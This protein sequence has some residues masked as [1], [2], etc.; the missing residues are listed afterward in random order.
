MTS[1]N[2]RIRA[3]ETELAGLRK[4]AMDE[5][6]YMDNGPFA[7]ALRDAGIP[8]T[9]VRKRELSELSMEEYAR[10]R[11]QFA[12]AHGAE[13]RVREL[14]EQIRDDESYSPPPKELHASDGRSPHPN[15]C[16]LPEGHGGQCPEQAKQFGEYFELPI[17]V[18][19]SLGIYRAFGGPKEISG[20]AQ[21]WYRSDNGYKDFIK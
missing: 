2:A 6:R 9:E 1:T 5:A 13:E 19:K 12:W 7:N 4:Q 16:P 10:L 20:S 15:W 11:Q 21:D 3:L 17:S 8:T 14:E 18:A